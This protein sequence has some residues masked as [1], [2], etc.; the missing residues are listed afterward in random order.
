MVNAKDKY[1]ALKR[2]VDYNPRI[3]AIIFCRTKIETQEVADKLIKDGYNA[4]ALH[5]DLSQQQRDLTM[6]KF[7]Q[8]TVQLLVATDVAARGLDVD[9][10]THVINFG[11][12][13]D[14]ENYTHRSGRTGRAGKKGTSICIV[15]SREKFKIRNIEKVIG[16]QFEQGVI[17]SAEEI[18][19]KQLYKVMDQIVKTDVDDEEIGPFMQDIQRYFE[20]IDKEEIIKKI[21]SMEFGKF[22]SYYADAPSL[23]PVHSPKGEGSK[24]AKG[25]REDGHGRKQPT[26]TSKGYKKLFINLGKRDGFYPGEL[27]QTLNRFVGGR[28]EVGHID[29][30][31]TISYFE[32]PEKDAKKVMIQLTGI[33]YKGRT[34]RCNDADEGSKAD[35]PS[36]P[37]ASRESRNS[38]ESREPRKKTP[39]EQKTYKKEDWMQFLAP[40]SKKLKGEVPD[41][42]EEGWAIR[43]PRKKK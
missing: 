3:F 33:R 17:P 20:F 43:K 11:L 22:L 24:D 9:D 4:E 5:G 8:H 30:L 34:V 23:T 31:D 29:L 16:K 35:K 28:Q 27:M 21:V 40:N 41:F 6:Q 25:K 2:I 7:R 38:R 1:L 42:S 37:R 13:D 18:C 14:I 12:P 26:P 19:K 10:L 36:S 15:H 39:K 32:V